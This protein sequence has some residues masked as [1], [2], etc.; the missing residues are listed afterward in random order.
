MDF[1]EKLQMLRLQKGLT[2]EA[3]ADKIGVTK[4]TLQGWEREGRLPKQAVIYDDLARELGVDAALLR[5]DKDLFITQAGEVYGSGSRRQAERLVEDFAGLC[6]GGSLSEEDKDAIMEAL[7]E[8]Y[9]HAKKVNK[10]YTPFRF[11]AE[12]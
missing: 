2:R 11:R 7:Q 5:S 3:L 4:R 12:E 1:G 8:A 9:W 6:A 10:K